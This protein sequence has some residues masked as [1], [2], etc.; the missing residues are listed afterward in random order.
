MNSHNVQTGY[1]RIRSSFRTVAFLR[2]T[3]I[4]L[5]VVIAIIAILATMLLP[6]LQKAKEQAK[7]IVC[8]GN[9]K[10]IGQAHINYLNDYNDFIVPQG[11]YGDDAQK[12]AYN[13]PTFWTPNWCSHVLLGQYFGN[14]TKD[15]TNYIN[16]PS[17]YVGW[18]Y[19]IK[20]ALNCPTGQDYSAT[21]GQD[22]YQTRYGMRTDIGW[23]G[24]PADWS[25]KMVRLTK[26]TKPSQEL[27]ILDGLD[28]RFGSGGGNYYGTKDGVANSYSSGPFCY[29]NW[30]RRHG[31]NS[32]GA[33]VLFIDSHV[34]Y[35]SD[36]LA[37]SRIGD[38]YWKY[39][40]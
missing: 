36:L 33:N 7:S 39:Y 11:I 1:R 29:T 40:P 21:H 34:S 38:V 14:T 2:F 32:N 12:I 26:V 27:I 3:I 30:A 24:S 18:N 10:N 6:A 31:A 19:W 15:T 17:P 22:A 37:S 5:M 25:I 16:N 4:E 9:L 28:S 23:I 35:S 13:Y 8:V 20:P